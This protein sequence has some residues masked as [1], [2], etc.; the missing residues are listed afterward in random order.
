MA[1][2][3]LCDERLRRRRTRRQAEEPRNPARE[4]PEG[5]SSLESRE[6]LEQEREGL[7]GDMTVSTAW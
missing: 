5:L 7:E 1:C 6:P 2:C 4:W 3:R